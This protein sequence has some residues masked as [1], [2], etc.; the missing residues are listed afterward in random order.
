MQVKPLFDRVLIVPNQD[1]QVNKFGIV[2]PETSQERPQTGEV[3]AIGDGESLDMDRA[4]MKVQVGD[5]VI[6]NKYAGTELKLEGKTYIVMRQIDI[7]G[8]IYD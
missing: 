7:I 6:F 3:V 1:E 8:V 2:L 4:Q 5:K